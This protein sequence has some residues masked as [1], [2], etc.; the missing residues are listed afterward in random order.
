P[1]GY[2]GRVESVGLRATTLRGADGER[3]FVPNGAIS[4][5]RVI[6]A[7]RRR[8]R[9]EALTRDPDAVEAA[10]RDL[11]GAVAGAGG[12]WAGPPRVVR[13]DAPEDLTRLIAVLELDPAR[14]GAP[15]AWLAQTLAD[16]AGD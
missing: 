14:A 5:V 16:R 13:R 1:S 12:P 3:M 11:A 8:V 7:G 15:D 4:G 6:P 2:I 10:I 9:I